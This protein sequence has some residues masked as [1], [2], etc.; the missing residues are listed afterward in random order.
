MEPSRFLRV[1]LVLAASAALGLAS[2][3]VARVPERSAAPVDVQ[4]VEATPMPTPTPTPVPTP[5]PTPAPTPGPMGERGTVEIPAI[6]A[7][8]PLVA[9][10]LDGDGEMVLPKNALDVA[11]LDNGGFPGP[12]RNAILA[13]HRNYSGV[14]GTFERLEDL[15]VG[16][17]VRVTVDGELHRYRVEWLDIYDPDTAPV[18]DLLGPTEADSLTLVTCGGAFDSS[19]RHYTKRWVARA[20]AVGDGAVE[21]TGEPQEIGDTGEP[22]GIG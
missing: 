7:E 16:D 1:V 10:G 19:V 12:T 20:T 13:G 5:E 6:G 18:G 2:S 8:G 22:P 17:E 4:R 14:S 21:S 15:E 3:A 11:W 9:V